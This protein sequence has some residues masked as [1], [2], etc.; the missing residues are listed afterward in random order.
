MKILAMGIFVVIL[1]Y[2]FL[3]IYAL[4]NYD[5]GMNDQ[6]DIYI[7]FEEEPSNLKSLSLEICD[8]TYHFNDKEIRDTIYDRIQI[9]SAFVPCEVF[10]K[11]IFEDGNEKR[12]ISGVFDCAACDGTNTFILKKDSVKYIYHP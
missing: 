1:I 10:T 2:A 8:S 12:F 7:Y 9:H 4:D 5:Y 3:G 6:I 11:Y